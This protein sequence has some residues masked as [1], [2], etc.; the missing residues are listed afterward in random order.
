M[1]ALTAWTMGTG[2]ALA[3]PGPPLDPA[4]AFVLTITPAPS[5]DL[6]VSWNVQ[7][8]YYLYRSKIA[9]EAPNGTS[10]PLTLPDGEVYDDP[11]L[12]RDEIYRTPVAITIP[13]PQGPTVLHWQGCQQDGICYAPQQAVLEVD[14]T[15]RAEEAVEDDPFGSWQADGDVAQSS[16]P[17]ADD[18]NTSARA[19]LTLA[20]GEG[21]V[22]DLAGRGGALLVLLGFFGFGLLLSLTPCVL[23]MVPIVA[24]M[25]TRQGQGLT[26]GRG[27]AL[28]GAYVIAMAAAFGL[29][30][31]VAAW[32]GANLQAVLQSPAAIGVI[33]AVFVMLALSM[34]G[35]FELQMPAAWQARLSRGTGATGSLGGAAVLGFGSALIVGPCVT[36]PLAGALIYIAQTGDVALGAAALFALGLGQGVPLLAVGAFGPQILPRRGAWME[37]VK[38]G[39]GVVFIAMAIWLAGRILPGPVVLLLWSVLLTGCGVALG[40]LDRLA[41]DASRTVRAAAGTGLLL[42]FAGLIQGIGAA[43]GAD[44][45]ARPLAPLADRKTQAVA[46]AVPFQTVTSQTA[47]ETALDGAQPAL[48]YVTADWCVTCRAIE[49]GP[50]SDPHVAAALGDLAR[51]KVDVTDFN[52]EAQAVMKTLAA[53][54]PPTMIFVDAAGT[55]AQGSRL[56]GDVDSAD[57][58][59]SIAQ[60]A[61]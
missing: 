55:E 30:G 37:R 29:L 28:T 21:L 59:A 3:E 20:E 11:W 8:G 53:A 61:P 52:A 47:L 1:A 34:F 33:A 32:S 7:P 14:G 4:E 22:A 27:L 5:G 38:I 56:I 45:P 39:F 12:G 26:A 15:I 36:A 44:D 40:A 6:Q 13:D 24:G 18:A 49:R 42:V 2:A 16:G 48:I 35:L 25:L 9:A 10:L 17:S 51:I 58:L 23:P 31:I 57:L 60:V 43:M 19:G 41:P 50:M 54:G 46:E